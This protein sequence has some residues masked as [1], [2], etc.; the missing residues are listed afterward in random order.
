[1]FA[2]QSDAGLYVCYVHRDLTVIGQYVFNVTS[3]SRLRHND[4]DDDIGGNV[5]VA[6]AR[7]Q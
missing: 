1:M 5:I 2:V 6:M 4:H 7:G 3:T